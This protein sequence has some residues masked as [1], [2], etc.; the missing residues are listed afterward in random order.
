VNALAKRAAAGVVFVSVL[1]GC[2]S[3]GPAV[4][5]RNAGLAALPHIPDAL[6][7]LQH[8]S[9]SAG[10]CPV[11]QVAIFMDGT[12]VY[13]GLTNVAVAGRRTGRLS[14][15]QLNRLLSDIA[16]IGFLDQPDECCVCP[17][18]DGSQ[19]VVVEYRPGATRKILVHDERCDRAPV[20]LSAFE[21]AIV[22]ETTIAR[23]VAPDFP[24]PAT[25]PAPPQLQYS[26]NEIANP[27]RPSDASEVRP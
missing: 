16:A 12:F 10:S 24:D 13:D 9:C 3:S 8:G 22:Q 1:A 14:A 27:A 7:R 26:A 20:A 21:R 17:T 25:A 6:I 2:G 15:E 18:T 19:L 23:W 5:G 4:S 11:Y